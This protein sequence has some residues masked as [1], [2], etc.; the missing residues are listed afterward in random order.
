MEPNRGT[1]ELEITFMP[2]VRQSLRLLPH[3]DALLRTLYRE[4]NIPTDQYPQRPGDLAKLVETWNSL[5]GRSEQAPDVMH[6]MITKRKQGQWERL[7]RETAEVLSSP[8]IQ[9]T[10]DELKHLDAIHEELQIASDN[11]ALNSDLADKLQKEFARRSGRIVPP[12]ILAAAIIHRRKIGAL[13]TLK[14]KPDDGDLGFSDID[15]IA[16]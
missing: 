13:A 12:M 16:K 2:K 4:F 3:E 14:P 7:G 9:F 5:T 8:R 11:F 15:K 10:E 1:T 6:Y